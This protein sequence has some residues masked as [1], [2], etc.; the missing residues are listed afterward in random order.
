MANDKQRFLALVKEFHTAMLVTTG[1]EGQLRARPMAVAR[2]DDSG[3]LYFITSLDSPM[4]DEILEDT[5]AAVT[6]QSATSYLS[7]S[8][9]CNV[10]RDEKLL[11]EL[12]SSDF[13]PFLAAKRNAVIIELHP[14]EAEYWS[15]EL[16]GLRFVLEAARAMLR[17][18][19][20]RPR[21][22]SDHRRVQ[23]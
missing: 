16:K 22:A 18:D 9:R 6:L 19:V 17:G 20:L 11:D 4:V 12:W 7:I 14:A 8:G 1:S 13:E 15:H 5:H 23:L 10:R 2:V 3:A 21:K